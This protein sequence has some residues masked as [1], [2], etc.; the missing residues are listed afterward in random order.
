MGKVIK[1]EDLCGLRDHHEGKAIVLAHGMF[2]LLHP[3]HIDHLKQAK[4]QGDILVVT[5]TGDKYSPK[6]RNPFFNEELRAKQLSALVMVDYVCVLHDPYSLKALK[7]LQP[8]TY[9]KG[10]EYKEYES[11]DTVAEK[12]LVESYGGKIHFT[13]GDVHS[14]TKI[15]YLLGQMSH[16]LEKEPLSEKGPQFVDLAPTEFK[17]STLRQF[18][19]RARGVRVCIIGETI[20]DEWMMDRI[21]GFSADNRCPNGKALTEVR[22]IGGAG[23]VAAHLSQFTKSVD[24]I[25]NENK[26]VKTRYMNNETG[27]AIYIREQINCDP[28]DASRLVLDGYDLVIVTDF[29]HGFIDKQAAYRIYTS[30]VPFLAVQAQT[31]ADN[32]GF[33]LVSK[34]KIAD[35]Y[36][37]NRMEAELLVGDRGGEP[38]LL[39]DATCEQLGLDSLSSKAISLTDGANGAWLRMDNGIPVHL[40]ALSK[41]VVDTI[42]CGDALFS[43]TALALSLKFSLKDSLLFGSIAAAVM[44]QRRGNG[45]P[46]TPKE[47]EQIWKVVT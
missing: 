23:I 31:N 19:K 35:Y 36:N 14:S 8:D 17:L 44:V 34:Y 2:D 15:G 21:R 33:N 12:N 7:E 40:P 1:V 16:A 5:I 9:V 47:L 4:E 29:G 46:V 11:P 28:I 26:V 13:H 42:G 32:F 38:G 39:L 6:R 43:L 10:E 41:S 20:I 37:L 25:T 18:L 30:R 22:Q 27:E 3:G 45:G 24:I